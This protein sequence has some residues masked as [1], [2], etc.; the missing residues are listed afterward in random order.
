MEITV[1]FSEPEQIKDLVY[2]ENHTYK[3]LDEGS[4]KTRRKKI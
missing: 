2:D 4:L 3:L 1:V